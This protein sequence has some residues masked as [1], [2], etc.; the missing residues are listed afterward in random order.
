M[1]EDQKLAVDSQVIPYQQ[2]PSIF[3]SIR[4]AEPSVAHG[5]PSLPMPNILPH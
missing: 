5:H 2:H 1:S 3:P 4:Y